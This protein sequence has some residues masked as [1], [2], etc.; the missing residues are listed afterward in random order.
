[1]LSPVGRGKLGRL[2]ASV[3]LLGMGWY[4]ALC[5]GGGAGIGVVFDELVGTKPILTMLG[6]GLGLFSA[7]IGGYFLL[8]RVLRPRGSCEEKD[9]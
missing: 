7:F 2:P 5:I 3:R 1:M 6:L 8:V 4:V 9:Y